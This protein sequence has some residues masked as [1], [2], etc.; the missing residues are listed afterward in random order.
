MDQEAKLWLDILSGG[1]VAITPEQTTAI[2]WLAIG[3]AALS[4]ERAIRAAAPAPVAPAKSEK[5]AKPKKAKPT[6]RTGR[7]AS[8][9]STASQALAAI[10]AGATTYAALKAALPK[11]ATKLLYRAAD[12][13][14]QR[15][16]ITRTRVEGEVRLAAR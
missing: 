6:K 4:L 11:V 16:A 10:K 15:G 5:P 13:L 12:Q 14:V 7:P 2:V 1:K 9:K 3:N 8:S